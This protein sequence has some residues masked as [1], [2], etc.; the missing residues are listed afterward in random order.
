MDL[1]YLFDISGTKKWISKLF[2]FFWKL[3]PICKFWVQN[4]SCALL[5]GWDICKT[6]W[7][8]EIHK[9]IFIWTWSGPHST[10]M[11]L[12]CPNWPLTG[13][14]ALRGL[15]LPKL[16]PQGLTGPV[17]CQSGHF[18]VNLTLLRSLQ[19]IPNLTLS[20]SEP[21]FVLQISHLPNMAQKWFCTQN[22]HMGLSFQKKKNGLEI[23][24]LGP[25]I[26]SKYKRSIFFGT[27]CRKLKFGTHTH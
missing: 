15:K 23:R 20:V 13:L 16:V 2:F 9:F 27:P 7:G 1:L 26:L 11:A 12:R 14:E 21:H 10:G 5:G 6:K 25:E 24:F 4:H 19:V 22:L 3:R 18:E 8:S 17:R